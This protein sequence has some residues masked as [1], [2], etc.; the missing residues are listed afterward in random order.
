[1][2]YAN[3]PL[4]GPPACQ[5]KNDEERKEVERGSMGNTF[6]SGSMGNVFASGTL[7]CCLPNGGGFRL[8][9]QQDKHQNMHNGNLCTT[10]AKAEAGAVNGAVPVVR[11]EQAPCL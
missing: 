8:S 3:S 7:P 5:L 1:M 9:P 11:I 10:T 6:A 2:V 4:L